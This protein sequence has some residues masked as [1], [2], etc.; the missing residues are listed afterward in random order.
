MKKSVVQLIVVLGI[1][2][3]LVARAGA[4]TIYVAEEQLTRVSIAS[5]SGPHQFAGGV[6]LVYGLALD[7]HGNV[8]AAGAGDDTIRRIT[9]GGAVSVYASGSAL[10]S[11]SGM[12]FDS[13]GNLYTSG[14]GWGGTVDRISPDGTI[15]HVASGVG[16]NG[17]AFDSSG[18]L[19]VANWD[20]IAKI[21]PSGTVS[22]F[23]TG[24]QGAWGLAFDS[25]GNLFV[26]N[27]IGD[28]INKITPDGTKSVFA[29]GLDRP[30]GLAFDE[31][32]NLFVCNITER[33]PLGYISQITPSGTVSTFAS[34]FNYPT[35]IAILV[36]EPSLLS[37]S[38]L[39]LAAMPLVRHFRR[40]KEVDRSA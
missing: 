32:G 14:Q 39:G 33:G 26:A 40:A 25:T 17:L 37:L 21:T 23:A 30:T 35:A 9:P 6:G 1:S 12:A 18:N 38:V 5:P 4:A 27:Y 7:G 8:Y 24:L 34:G 31:S 10:G 22:T 20:S 28:Y 11:P 3:L 16:G 15:T 36:P 2:G 29:T 19:Y 13:A